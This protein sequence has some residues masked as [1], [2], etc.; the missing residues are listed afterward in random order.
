MNHLFK[1]SHDKAKM[2]QVIKAR[3]LAEKAKYENIDH[4]DWAEIA[5]RKILSTIDFY[6]DEK[7][8]H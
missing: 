6:L 8:N 3:I 7:E 5:A 4:M 2:V 1:T